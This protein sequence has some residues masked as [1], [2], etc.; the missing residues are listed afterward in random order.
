M[1]KTF[2]VAADNGKT[3]GA[4]DEFVRINLCGY[5]N[6]FAEFLNRLS[7]TKKYKAK[8]LLITSAHHCSR[9]II[10]SSDMTQ[11]VVNPND[12]NIDIDAKHSNVTIVL[13]Q[14]INYQNSNRIT[15]KK[16]ITR[17]T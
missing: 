1:Y 16:L 17:S 2:N 11:Y 14:F 13:P 7:K 9:T 6:D 4:S 3:M 10:R 5:S 12:C 15:I 8:D